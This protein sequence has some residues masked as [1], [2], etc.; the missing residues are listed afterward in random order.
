LSQS[1]PDSHADSRELRLAGA[2]N[3]R[4]LGGL[5]TRSG[6]WTRRGRLFRGELMASLLEGDVDLLIGEVGL[7]G[8]V[9]L[10]SRGEVRHHPGTWLEHGVAWVHCPFRLGATAPVP[11]PGV[12]YVASYLS[13]LESDPR[14]VVQAAATLMDPNFHP[15]LFHCAAS[16][17]IASY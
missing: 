7:S 15:A 10:R 9:D 4:D 2:D 1:V 3:V 6:A 5:P 11:G 17:P 8:V 13:F 14:P 16:S 12:D